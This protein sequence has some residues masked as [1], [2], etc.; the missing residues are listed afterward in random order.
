MTY[1][2]QPSPSGMPPWAKWTLIGCAG[3]LTV[4][5]L[6][7]VGCG[8]LSYYLFGRNM[9]IVDMSDKPDLPLTATA[10]QLLP[11]RVARSRARRWCILTRKLAPCPWGP[12]G[13]AI[14]SPAASMWTSR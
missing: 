4:T 11:P 6:G 13:R 8:A 7:M 9:K 5:L 10:G 2:T 1:P 12:S 14:T 3:C